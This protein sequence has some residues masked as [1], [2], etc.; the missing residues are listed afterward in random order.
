MTKLYKYLLIFFC[1]L[2]INY[3]IV[4]GQQ[5]PVV[6]QY[7]FNGLVL[8]PAYAGSLG[9]F[10]ATALYRNQWV[11]LEGA[12]QITTFTANSNI[13]GKNIG[14]GFLI[15]NDQVG[16]HSDL[17]MYTSYSYKVKLPVGTLA[18]GLQAGFNNTISNF[19][20]VLIED[21]NDAYFGETLSKF[22]LNFG[23]GVYYYTKN[24]YAGISIPYLIKNRTLKDINV[25]D[26]SFNERKESRNYYIT[27]GHLF[28]LSHSVKIKP[29]TLIRIEDGMP[30]AFDANLNM[31]L[32]DLVNVGLSYREG[33]SF[34]TLFELQ[35]TDYISFGYAYDWIIS[36]LN[37]F[38]SGTHEFML[39]YRINL[40]AP[41]KHRM[42][43]GPMYF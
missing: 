33:D 28:D 1:L 40:F 38:T 31:F 15:T 34:T 17:G 21:G 29:S 41:R 19:S 16:V 22:K 39:N 2:M 11:N 9:Y 36:E 14:L 23:T 43:P 7:M 8:N 18:M 5:R 42:C 27:T 13:K 4:K 20:E 32:E 10:Q 6:S 37:Y 25:R 3:T 24:F 26:L 35:I 12:P 30:I